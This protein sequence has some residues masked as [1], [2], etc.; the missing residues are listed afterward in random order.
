MA[1]RYPRPTRQDPPQAGKFMEQA[2]PVLMPNDG[3]EGNVRGQNLPEFNAE[4]MHFLAEI[5]VRT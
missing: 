1:P 5:R 2:N 4:D 3:Q